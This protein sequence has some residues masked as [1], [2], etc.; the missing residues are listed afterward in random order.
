M[1]PATD[2]GYLAVVVGRLVTSHDGVNKMLI[3]EILPKM[4]ETFRVRIY[5]INCPDLICDLFW[6]V[7]LPDFVVLNLDRKSSLHPMDI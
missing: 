5:F 2:M 1:Q 3:R 4:V 7:K 6:V